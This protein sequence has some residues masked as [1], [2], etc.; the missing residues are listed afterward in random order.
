MKVYR[1]RIIKTRCNTNTAIVMADSV[2]TEDEDLK[3]AIPDDDLGECQN[4]SIF[5]ETHITPPDITSLENPAQ[6]LLQSLKTVLWWQASC[7]RIF[8]NIGLFQSADTEWKELR[9]SSPLVPNY[10]EA[11]SVL[12]L[13]Q[14]WQP[15]RA[16]MIN[17]AKTYIHGT[18]DAKV[19][20]EAVIMDWI[21]TG[22][23]RLYLVLKWNRFQNLIASSRM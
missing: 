16:F 15:D 13:I 11:S 12:P 8:K 4:C 23:V 9:Y 17:D 20:A 7:Q 14:S 1:E 5:D 21:T 19:H 18:L 3:V 2:I 22:K 6:R 10:L